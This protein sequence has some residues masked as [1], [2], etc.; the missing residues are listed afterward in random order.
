M[1]RPRS[2]RSSAVGYRDT[3][4]CR[5]L[6]PPPSGFPISRAVGTG[7]PRPGEHEQ[8]L[9]AQK[10]VQPDVR[11]EPVGLAAGT[12]AHAMLDPQA[13]LGAQALEILER[14]GVDAGRAVPR[15][16]QA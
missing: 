1:R 8:G 11:V 12:E 10:V 7:G 3:F 9:L 4:R 6:W 13:E 14:A 16:G 15:L 2:R 5:A